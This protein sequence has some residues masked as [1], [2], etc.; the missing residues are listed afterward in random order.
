MVV[1]VNTILAN[2]SKGVGDIQT[3]AKFYVVSLIFCDIPVA[4][5]LMVAAYYS[6]LWKQNSVAKIEQ[7]NL[8]AE[9]S[10]GAEEDAIRQV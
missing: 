1:L 2:A 6:N 3:L 4:L 9:T 7:S 10:I 8:N 5:A